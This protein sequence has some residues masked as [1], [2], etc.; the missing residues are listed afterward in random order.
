MMWHNVSSALFPDNK[1]WP[2][3]HVASDE[4]EVLADIYRDEINMVLWQRSHQPFLDTC[5]QDWV[6]YHPDH[7]VKLFLPIEEMEQQLEPALPSVNDIHSLKQDITLLIEMFSCLFDCQAVGLR[8]TPLQSTMCPRFHVDNIPC[9]L[10]MTYGG[11][12]TEWLTENNVNRAALSKK[13]SLKNAESEFYYDSKMIQRM[14]SQQ[15][16]L[17]KGSGWEGNETYGV[18]HRSPQLMSTENRL[19]LTLDF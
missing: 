18:V 1:I 6:K 7:M 8:L 11:P 2:A 16:A 10:V 12:G 5:A 14:E 17:L 3:R 15:L 4:T 9:R 19:L 13:P